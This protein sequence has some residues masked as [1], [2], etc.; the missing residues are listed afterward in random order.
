M[1]V[2]NIVGV[3]AGCN[4]KSINCCWYTMPLKE[5]HVGR[6][7]GIITKKKKDQAAAEGL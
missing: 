3:K 5:V 7:S 4:L 2:V 6:I 1:I